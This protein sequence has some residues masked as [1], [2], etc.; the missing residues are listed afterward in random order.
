[1]AAVAATTKSG[2]AGLDSITVDYEMLR[3]FPDALEPSSIPTGGSTTTPMRATS[4][5]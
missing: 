2:R 3:A 4:T 1:V 5:S